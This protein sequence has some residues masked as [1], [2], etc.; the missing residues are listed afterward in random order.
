M[1]VF[2]ENP[3]WPAPCCHGQQQGCGVQGRNRCAA[4]EVAKLYPGLVLCVSFRCLHVRANDVG[5]CPPGAAVYAQLGGGGGHRRHIA[6]GRTWFHDRRGMRCLYFGAAWEHHLFRGDS[7]QLPGNVQ[8]RGCHDCACLYLC[9]GT[10]DMTIKHVRVSRRTL[11]VVLIVCVLAAGQMAVTGFA[12]PDQIG[13]QL[14][15]ATFL[16]LFGIS[17]AIVMIAGG[18]GLDLSVGAVATL[19][20]IVGAAVLDVGASG[21]LLSIALAGL[22]GFLVGA[23][24][25]VGITVFKVPPLVMTLAMASR[26]EEHT[27]ELHSLMR[28]S[29]AVFCLKTKNRATYTKHLEMIRALTEIIT[30]T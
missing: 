24:N 15:I 10:K 18:Q 25:G 5:R 6:G 16:G 12:G 19:G 17:Q 26:S 30:H 20:G 3:V 4:S 23:L 7:Q 29:Y 11:L 21:L 14:K 2:T 8:G 28:I 1:G 13:N 27:S 9:R 22:C